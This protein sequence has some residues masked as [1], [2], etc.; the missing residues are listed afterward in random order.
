MKFKLGKK[1]TRVTRWIF[2]RFRTRPK[3]RRL[4]ASPE[5]SHLTTKLLTWGRNLT[6]KAKSLCSKK[7][8][9]RSGYLPVGKDPVQ[10][11]GSPVP[12][13]HLAVYVGQKDGEFRRVLVPVVYFNHP[14]FSELLKETEKEYGFCHQGGIT[15]PCR[16]TE[17]EQVKTRIASG[18]GLRRLGRRRYL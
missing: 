3:Y 13:G 7:G 1:V 10:E 14:L 6:T 8:L 5:K 15:I 17:F 16:V 4:G 2:R 12:K 11:N 9:G 18:S